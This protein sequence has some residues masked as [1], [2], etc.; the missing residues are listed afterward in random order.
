MDFVKSRFNKTNSQL[1]C[2]LNS[3]CKNSSDNGAMM[4]LVLLENDEMRIKPTCEKTIFLSLSFLRA[5]FGNLF[6]G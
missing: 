1:F 2:C 3:R 4:T 5:F 6:G